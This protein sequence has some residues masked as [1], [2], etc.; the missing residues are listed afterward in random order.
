[1]PIS[2]TAFLDAVSRNRQRVSSYRHGQDGSSGACDCIGLIIGA[3]RL[4]GVSYNG[5]HGSNWFI[6][7]EVTAYRRISSVNDLAPGDIIFKAYEKGASGWQLPERYWKGSDLRDYYHVGVVVSVSPL[8][9]WHCTSRGGVGGVYVDNK[10]GK[11][12]YH[13]RAK[14][15]DYQAAELPPQERT[16][17]KM[18]TMRVYSDNGK[19]ANMRAKQSTSSSLLDR[20]P[21]NAEVTVL[22]TSGD[23]SRVTYAGRTGY[24][25]SKF[26]I[27]PDDPSETGI[28]DVSDGLNDP[29]Q[30]Y[31]RTLT[32]DEY[33]RL[34]E[35]ADRMEKDA[36]F[37]RTIVGVG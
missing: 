21:E 24:V 33:N 4:A 12:S 7:N 32:P 26:L 10:L 2:V 9:I 34:G 15:I 16:E 37:L 14:A 18:V 20:I 25:M 36:A 17:E 23:W 28:P 35:I 1:M 19:G 22:D 3:F 5:M 31:V 30:S 27:K 13:A 8:A 11:W 6:R 29:V